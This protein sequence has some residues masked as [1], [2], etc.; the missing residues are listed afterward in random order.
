MTTC[1]LLKL[2]CIFDAN[3]MVPTDMQKVFITV[4]LIQ[5]YNCIVGKYN[6][7]FKYYEDVEH[8]HLNSGVFA[9]AF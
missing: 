9:A 1:Q 6:D 4:F 7:H 3:K 8:M 2:L 5:Q